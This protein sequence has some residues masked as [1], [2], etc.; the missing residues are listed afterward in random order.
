MKEES[1]HPW[2]EPEL[3]ARIVALVLGEA[4]DF[5][6]E[7]LTH[8]I[9]SKSELLVFR[10]RMESLH[11]LLREVAT[12]ESSGK[13][14]GWKLSDERRQAVLSVIDGEGKESNPVTLNTAPTG[15]VALQ[16]HKKTAGKKE[17]ASALSIAVIIHLGL[18]AILMLYVVYQPLSPPPQFSVQSKASYGY[19]DIS[20]E[21]VQ[22]MKKTKNAPSS[23]AHRY[24]INEAEIASRGLASM[25]AS[26][27]AAEPNPARASSSALSSIQDSLN[28]FSVV[29]EQ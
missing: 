25:S 11:G 3:E 9:E 18:A 29:S 28:Q 24:T 13:N 16:P 26:T 17:K 12:G 1:L 22:K 14:Y 15:T 8:L 20:S 23:V 2:I 27:E 4:S 5:E 10:N 6:Q 7:E 21:K 19:D